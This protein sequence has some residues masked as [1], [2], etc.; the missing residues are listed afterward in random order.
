MNANFQAPLP[1]APP[2]SPRRFYKTFS[3]RGPY[4]PGTV[5]GMLLLSAAGALFAC[6]GAYVGWL[7]LKYSFG[8]VEVDG[9]VIAIREKVSHDSEGRP[10][11]G[12]YPVV[13]YM[14]GG[15]VYTLTGKGGSGGS[16]AY[17]IDEPVRVLYRPGDPLDA[18]LNSFTERWLGPLFSVV[19]GVLAAFL[20]SIPAQHNYWLRHRPS[21]PSTPLVT[22]RP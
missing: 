5:W 16:S 6:V 15:D 18:Q 11:T 3:E 19:G 17:E 2:S 4:E 8:T 1:A 22:S 12:Y 10:S 13:R 14:V 9:R 7:S 21:P 20:F